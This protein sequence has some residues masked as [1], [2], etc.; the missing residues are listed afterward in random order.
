[1]YLLQRQGDNSFRLV[2]RV[3]QHIPPYAI[4]SH[5]WGPDGDEVTFRDLTEGTGTM[6]PG[7]R[8]INFCAKQAAIDDLQFFWIDTCCIDKS[9][10]S[11]LL[12]AINCMFQW[13]RNSAKCYVYLED[14][15]NDSL[16]K[17]RMAFQKS[18]W[19]TRGW[20]L[21]E[22]LAPKCVEFFSKEGD[23]FG[24]KSSLV[25][26][27]AGITHIP[28]EALRETALS[29]FSVDQRM[30]WVKG[31]ETTREEDLAY[32]LLGVFDIQMSLFYG[33]GRDRAFKRLYKKIAHL[34]EATRG[35]GGGGGGGGGDLPL[36]SD[37]FQF[38]LQTGTM[39][40]ET[41]ANFRLLM[42]DSNKSGRPDL[43]AAKRTGNT[44]QN[45]EVN[46]LYGDSEYEKFLL[47]I[48]TPNFTPL[49]KRSTEQLDF[50]LADW[51]G[52][53]TL[54]LIVIKRF[55][56][57]TNSTEVHIFSG[58]SKFQDIML[59]VGTPL[60]ETDYTWSFGMGRWGIGNKPD[61]FAIKRSNTGSK[62]TEVH[63][64]SGDTNF[65]QFILQVGTGL[66][67]TD[68]RFDFIVTDWNGDGRPD[69]V[70]IKKSETSNKCTEVYVLSGA[71]TYKQFIQRSETPL[72][73]S[74]G[75]YEFAA[76][77]WTGNGK[78]DLIAFKKEGTESNSTEVHVMSRRY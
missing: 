62:S 9:S 43:I 66:H 29:H 3:G 76:A 10:S 40:H 16:A 71:S 75:L 70:A 46:V 54:D 4:L 13:Y 72:F 7:Y 1:M 14:V 51:N 56:T 8:K 17:D 20:T 57:G 47:R 48:A 61:L 65:Q 21:Q 63:V 74:N 31:R 59:Q 2:Y 28:A 60:E 25:W 32:S 52:D 35:H 58:A 73:R 39:L 24:S 42:G 53:G 5:T 67:E 34:E 12:E 45:I 6:K 44:D 64:L 22:L 68:S 78:P 69:L 77:D 30:V 41:E 38:A 49:R 36:R 27:I 18:R 33:E 19:F 23:L 11:E 50:A 55:E 37:Y 15:P 26:D